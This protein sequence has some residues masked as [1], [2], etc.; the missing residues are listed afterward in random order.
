MFEIPTY[1]SFGAF[2]K[3]PFHLLIFIAHQHAIKHFLGINLKSIDMLLDL[4]IPRKTTFFYKVSFSE[5]ENIE[6]E[7]I[8]F[9][10]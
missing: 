3:E 5:I 2:C 10:L 4:V 1:L 6:R 7:S 9:Q 8:Y